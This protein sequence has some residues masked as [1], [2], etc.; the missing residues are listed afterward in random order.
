M[1]MNAKKAFA[2]LI[3]LVPLMVIASGTALLRGA[4]GGRDAS[5]DQSGSTADLVFAQD[6]VTYVVK[7]GAIY[8]Q[9]TGG[10]LTFVQQWYDPGFVNDYQTVDGG[11]VQRD[12]DSGLLYPV[13][14][15]F[16]DG[17]E[18]LSSV[19]DLFS[20][21]RW[22]ASDVDPARAGRNDNYYNLGNRVGISTSVVHSGTSA[23]RFSATPSATMTSK[24]SIAKGIMYFTKGDNVYTSG[25]FFL[26]NTP[27]VY[28]IGGFTLFDF[29]STVLSGIGIRVIFRR[30]DALA[31]ELELPK[32]RFDQTQG[33]AVAFPTGRWVK[34]DSH[35][36]LTDAEQGRARIWQDGV[37]V[38]DR[39]GRTLPM[40]DTVYDRFEIGISAIAKG[41]K[42]GKV[43]Y[44]DD[45]AI[46][47][48]PLPIGP[49]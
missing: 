3:M 47:D 40:A 35:I 23:L 21:E 1:Y 25:W 24:A 5:T 20:M 39:Q 31:F 33:T 11:V 49:S 15:N 45:V 37:L 10:Q 16:S 7:D 44:V 32:T 2:P 8:Q 48:T 28:D 22:H 19:Q 6:G 42:Y 46:A 34:I 13:A 43:L 14:R 26:E 4:G 41:S 18:G 36:F 30:G 27:S 38:M 12:P 17:F 9:Q 29:E